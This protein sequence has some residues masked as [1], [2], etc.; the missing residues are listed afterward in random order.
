MQSVSFSYFT[1]VVSM[2][3]MVLAKHWYCGTRE[4]LPHRPAPCSPSLLR[5]RILQVSLLT[6]TLSK[7]IQE[8]CSSTSVFRVTAVTVHPPVDYLSVVLYFWTVSIY[9]WLCIFH[10]LSRPTCPLPLQHYS[11]CY[12][13]WVQEGYRLVKW[14]SFSPQHLCRSPCIA[15]LDLTNESPHLPAFLHH[16]LCTALH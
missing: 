11:V 9:K 15:I 1:I 14:A 13:K 16:I 12:T 10:L 4:C 2:F 3:F 6:T 5:D 8:V 7:E